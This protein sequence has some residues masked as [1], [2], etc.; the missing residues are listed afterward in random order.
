M[1]TED[2]GYPAGAV[3]FAFLSGAVIGVGAALL[4]A[5]RSGAETRRL[6]KTYAEKAE[7]E[8]LEKAKEAKATLDTTIEQCKQFIKEKK[9]VLTEAFEAGKEA[10]KG[11]RAS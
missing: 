10:L 1:A 11:A 7:E 6:L 5:P 9:A 8:V 3:G 4:L 2:N